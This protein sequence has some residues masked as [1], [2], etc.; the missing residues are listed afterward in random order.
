MVVEVYI[1]DILVRFPRTRILAKLWSFFEKSTAFVCLYDPI[2]PYVNILC[3]IL[4]NHTLRILL[5]CI[6]YILSVILYS[7]CSLI[8][9]NVQILINIFTDGN[10]W[11]RL[12]WFAC[13]SQLFTWFSRAHA[14]NVFLV[15]TSDN[16]VFF[17]GRL[18]MLFA[19]LQS[20]I[21]IQYSALCH[22]I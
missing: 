11:T 9:N 22:Q 15:C 1:Y 7:L 5:Y 2:D 3:C 6:C 4:I 18:Q 19:F 17:M 8:H 13:E 16:F 14:P 21:L 20:V 10:L 12:T